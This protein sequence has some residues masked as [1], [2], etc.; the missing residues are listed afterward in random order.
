MP[1][2]LSAVMKKDIASETT[3]TTGGPV[4][5]NPELHVSCFPKGVHR[6]QSPNTR[7]V[8]TEKFNDIMADDGVSV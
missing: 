6:R 4:A 7:K 3:A 2:E 1:Q 5:V 8:T